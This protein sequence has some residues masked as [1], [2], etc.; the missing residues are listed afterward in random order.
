MQEN[1]TATPSPTQEAG[2]IAQPHTP[3]P[4][5]ACNMIHAERGDQMTPEELGEYVANNV[6]KTLED[7]GFDHFLFIT[8]PG[9]GPDICHVGNGPRGPANARLIAASPNLLEALDPDTLEAIADA[10][11]AE[12]K[13]GA[14][15]DGLRVIAKRQRSAIRLA[16]EGR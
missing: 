7:G 16:T 9:D 5:I 4:W 6:R 11:G 3:G 15:A 14:R 8:T 13:H 10:I 12:F 1:R 2:G